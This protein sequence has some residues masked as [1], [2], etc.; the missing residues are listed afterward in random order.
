MQIGNVFWRLKV[1]NGAKICWAS[2]FCHANELPLRLVCRLLAGLFWLGKAERRLAPMAAMS[3]LKRKASVVSKLLL[4]SAGSPLLFLSGGCGCPVNRVLFL[5][6]FSL[7]LTGIPYCL[8]IGRGSRCR[9]DLV[10]LCV[11]A[12]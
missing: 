12:V 8:F 6:G 7:G 5:P 4:S 10:W 1:R 9:V 3:I 2:F 11:S